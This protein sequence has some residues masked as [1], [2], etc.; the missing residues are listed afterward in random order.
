MTE[1]HSICCQLPSSGKCLS[2]LFTLRQRSPR[3]HIDTAYLLTD[4]V[5][6]HSD[7]RAMDSEK[8]HHHDGEGYIYEIE[9][10]GEFK[11]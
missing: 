5:S 3:T 9:E 8:N 10:I 7:R 1:A 6:L 2:K 11:K 4:D